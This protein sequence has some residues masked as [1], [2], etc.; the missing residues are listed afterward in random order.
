AAGLS[1]APLDV[2]KHTLPF[3]LEL[4]SPLGPVGRKAEAAWRAVEDRLLCLLPVLAP[5]RVQV[6][7]ERLCQG[8][9]HHFAEISARLSPREDHPLEDGNAGIAQ[10][11]LRVHLAAG[12]HPVAV[13]T[14]AER[15]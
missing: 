7:L 6:E 13:G 12:T 9:Q 4:T 3:A 10:H 11:Q 2:A 8:R 5:G 14:G 1:I 15:G